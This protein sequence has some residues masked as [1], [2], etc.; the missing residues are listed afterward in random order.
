MPTMSSPPDHYIRALTKLKPPPGSWDCHIHLFGPKS[1]YPHQP[2]ADYDRSPDALPG[3]LLRS[4]ESVGPGAGGDRSTMVHGAGPQP[5]AGY[6]S[7]IP[8]SLPGDRG[9]I[10]GYLRPRTRGDELS[11][12]A[13]RAGGRLHQLAGHRSPRRGGEFNQ[14]LHCPRCGAGLACT[15][16]LRLVRI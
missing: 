4:P 5:A 12:R 8:G 1:R 16:C 11:W 10:R 6:A 7:P 15:E 3:V 14:A 9:A 13:G 2:T